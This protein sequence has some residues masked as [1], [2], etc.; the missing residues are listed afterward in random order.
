[1]VP[2][3]NRATIG[4]N[5]ASVV[6]FVVVVHIRFLYFLVARYNLTLG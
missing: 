2:R 4:R 3:V 1:M 6:Q 5:R